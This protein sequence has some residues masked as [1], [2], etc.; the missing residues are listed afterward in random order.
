MPPPAQRDQER[1][2]NA[3]VRYGNEIKSCAGNGQGWSGKQQ[4]GMPMG[5]ILLG[6]DGRGPKAPAHPNQRGGEK[7]TWSSQWTGKEMD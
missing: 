5:F 4:N 7:Y 1:E 6:L 3:N 2:R